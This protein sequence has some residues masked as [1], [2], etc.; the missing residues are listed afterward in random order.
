M[1]SQ[2]VPRKR[3][4]F[5]INSLA[6]GGAERVMTTL[7]RASID[8]AAEFELELFLLDDEPIEYPLPAWLKVRQFDSRR[9]LPKTLLALWRGFRAFRPDL[10]LSFLTRANVAAIVVGRLCG[11]PVIVSERVNTSSHLGEGRAAALIKALVR[12]TYPKAARIIA[13]S[14]GVADDLATVFG[15]PK[16][17]IV[18]IANPIDSDAIRAAAEVQ[19]GPPAGGRHASEPYVAAMGRLVPNKN[20]ALLIEAFARSRIGGRLLIFGEGGERENL[21]RLIKERGLEGSVELLG[22]SSNPFPVLRQA[23]YFVLPSNAEGFP[24]ALLEAMS[25]G[26]PVISTNCLSG[27][28]EILAEM[29]RE[30]VPQPLFFAEHGIIVAPNAPDALAEAMRAMTDQDRRD[31]YAAKALA[32]AA[33]YSVTRSKDQYWNV[34]RSLLPGRAA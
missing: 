22:F 2:A 5:V 24:N 31:H 12:W 19:A 20:F 7:L 8:E 25:C 33:A 13:V 30:Q 28:S 32:R 17:K 15:L 34:L 1:Q 6:G 27:P 29:P 23:R 18:V 16:D 21:I 11:V 4:A 14:P 9:S 3:V 26:L 10:V